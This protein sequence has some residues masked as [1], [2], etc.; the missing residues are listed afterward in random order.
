MDLTGKSKPELVDQ[1][2]TLAASL[3]DEDL[4]DPATYGLVSQLLQILDPPADPLPKELV[5]RL[6]QIPDPKQRFMEA[7]ITVGAQ[8]FEE[9]DRLV[10]S[11]K[12]HGLFKVEDLYDDSLIDH[13]DSLFKASPPAHGVH[14]DYQD[15]AHASANVMFRVKIKGETR[16]TDKIPLH[17][18]LKV[19]HKPNEMPT[20]EIKNVAQALDI[21]RP[22]TSKLKFHTS[23]FNSPRTGLDYYMLHIHGQDDAY[24]K[25]VNH[26]K[27]RGITH[28]KFMHHITI[29]KNL[30]DRIKSEGLQPH[31]I[32][33]SPL[34]IEHGADNPIHIFK[35][36]Q[37]HD[38]H[39]KDFVPKVPEATE[40]FP[41]YKI[42]KAEDMSREIK[43]KAAALLEKLKK[44]QE[45]DKGVD[46]F[47]NGIKGR[48]KR[49]QQAK[50]FGTK[51]DVK[52]K[53]K[54]DG[55]KVHSYKIPD[56]NGKRTSPQR[57]KMMNT[58]KNYA[59][60][61]TG[62]KMV[63]AEGKR[64]ETGK[65]KNKPG[66]DKEP[67]D[68]FSEKGHEQEKARQ[69]KIDA[70]NSELKT[71][72]KPMK[73]VDPKPDHR[74]GNLETQPS[75]D[76][77]VHEIAHEALS[78]KGMNMADH[79]THMDVRWG[80]SQ[81]KYG[82]MQQKKTAGEIQPM[83]AENPLRREMGLPANKTHQ[84]VKDAKKPVEQTV[85]ET[86]PRFHRG[87]DKKGNA[88]DLMR[89]SRLLHPENKE[90]IESLRDGTLK[91]SKEGITESTSVD[92]KI[93]R[94]AKQAAQSK[95]PPQATESVKPKSNKN[96]IGS[97][98]PEKLAANE[99]MKA[100][101]SYRKLM[102]AESK[103]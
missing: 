69:E 44:S 30:Y 14:K 74:S 79:Q 42:A 92:A 28:E 90:R 22:D 75:P 46:E 61:K 5:E 36:H 54:E 17:Q 20:E 89:Q 7:A 68:V 53:V 48:N 55:S 45:L 65:L 72:Q 101:W 12:S 24:E 98:R 15:R 6:R 52:T 4:Q 18:S 49:Y 8:G 35:D 32:E 31:E 10:E 9:I 2:I 96:H 62:H 39:R 63:I 66:I 85:D 81:K 27:G 76:A 58:I 82:H 91:Y 19:F 78:P 60:K 50:V 87:K 29:N 23:I 13:L 83:A 34:L 59:E 47:G 11:L 56:A 26:F 21:K 102:K 84:K 43:V 100:G 97:Q 41:P 40:H 16:L 73:R 103:K 3:K 80:E 95:Q 51:S 77:A 86:G 64:D 57:M 93:N 67:F 1:L 71:G 94:R 88:V 25:F 70:H 33:Y 38:D 99:Q 37:S